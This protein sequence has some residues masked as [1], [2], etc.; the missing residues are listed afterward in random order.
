MTVF[1]EKEAGKKWCPNTF[2]GGAGS[3]CIGSSCMAW[4][5]TGRHPETR[6]RLCIDAPQATIEPDP[7]PS[8][9]PSSWD[10]VPYMDEDDDPAGWI[11]PQ[12]EA[13]ARRLGYCGAFGRPE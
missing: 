1:T 10:W 8:N 5:W 9:I 4:R 6:F 7:R 11:E 2:N 12:E 3:C 13:S